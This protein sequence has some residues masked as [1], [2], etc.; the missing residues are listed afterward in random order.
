MQNLLTL[1]APPQASP[2]PTLIYHN[3]DRFEY[4]LNS[5]DD[6]VNFGCSV[7]LSHHIVPRLVEVWEFMPGT[8]ANASPEFAPGAELDPEISDLFTFKFSPTK[9]NQKDLHLGMKIL[10][11]EIATGLLH[12]KGLLRLSPPQ[13]AR[14]KSISNRVV[15]KITKT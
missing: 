6:Y 3:P 7:H 13:K 2:R 10:A 1:P 11:A 4:S 8:D 14:W 9:S 12:T 5:P 15:W